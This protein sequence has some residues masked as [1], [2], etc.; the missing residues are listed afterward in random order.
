MNF[1]GVLWN[2]IFVD[3]PRRLIIYQYFIFKHVCSL[4]LSKEY[5]RYYGNRVFI[6]YYK[7]SGICLTHTYVYVGFIVFFLVRSQR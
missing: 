4:E 7:E 3:K 5:G 6:L 1:N 2:Y